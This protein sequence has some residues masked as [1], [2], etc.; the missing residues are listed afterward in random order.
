VG[1]QPVAA[2]QLGPAG[3]GHPRAGGPV[4]GEDGLGLGQGEPAQLGRVGGPGGG[5]GHPADGPAQVDR[6]RPGPLQGGRHPLQL[7]PGGGQPLRP[8]PGR[9]GLVQAQHHPER[10]RDPDGRRPPDGQ[11]PQ[12]VHDLGDGRQLEGGQPLGEQ[13]LV[14]DLQPA[15]PPADGAA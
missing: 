3:L 4:L 15:V 12:R 11:A 14:D 8:G 9:A 7:V 1:E 13:R 10:T 6:G 2:G 5:P